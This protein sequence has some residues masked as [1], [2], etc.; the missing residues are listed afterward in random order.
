MSGSAS[1]ATKSLAK[2][3]KYFPGPRLTT[4]AADWACGSLEERLR[5]ICGVIRI[6]RRQATWT[7]IRHRTHINERIDRPFIDSWNTTWTTRRKASWLSAIEEHV[8]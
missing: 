1:S 3:N 8:T 4:S 2:N 5:R 6:S 7:K